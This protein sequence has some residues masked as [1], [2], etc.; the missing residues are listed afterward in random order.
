M[1]HTNLNPQIS[2]QPTI[3][4]I[5]RAQCQKGGEALFAP[6]DLTLKSGEMAVIAGHNGSGKTTLLEAVAGLGTFYRGGIDFVPDN[7]VDAW[8]Q[9]SHYLGHAL[10]NKASLTCLENINF[11]A[12]M[13]GVHADQD[14]LSAALNRV[15]LGGYEYHF[16][17]DLSAGQKKRLAL[18]R[19]L[20]LNKTF[21]LLDEPF[22]NLDADGCNW[23]FEC[24]S[25]H[26]ANGGATL[27]TAHD[28]KRIHEK[29]DH[30]IQLQRP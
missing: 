21:W 30:L 5:S 27:L 14:R 15:G 25:E 11:A 22:V 10:G 16:A 17:N 6:V 13:N 4:H 18:S 1:L 24:I 23:L 8:R 26:V 19:L 20:V 28:N 3:L 9:H 2:L 29:C 7:T 12:T